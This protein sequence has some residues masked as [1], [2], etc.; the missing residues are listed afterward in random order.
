ME[1][2]KSHSID[3]SYEFKYVT[4]KELKKKCYWQMKKKRQIKVKK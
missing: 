2:S 3:K 1:M 4:K